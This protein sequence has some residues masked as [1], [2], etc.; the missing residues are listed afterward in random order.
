M[1]LGSGFCRAF[2]RCMHWI[3]VQPYN[4]LIYIVTTV[5]CFPRANGVGCEGHPRSEAGNPATLDTQ[6][7]LFDAV[8]GETSAHRGI[9][10]RGRLAKGPL[11][12]IVVK[13]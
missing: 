3:R 5:T 8:N 6:S 1:A 7:E 10:K 4:H 9:E 11:R 13:R 2:K 12:L